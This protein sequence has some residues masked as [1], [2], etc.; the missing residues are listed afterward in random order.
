MNEYELIKNLFS[1]IPDLFKTDAS[2]VDIGKDKWGITCD[3]FSLEED[4]FTD[5]NPY[6]L[7]HNMAVATIS[8][9]IAT[10]CQ[11]TFY[12]HSLITSPKYDENWYEKLIQGIQEALKEYKMLL[13]GGDM[14]QSSKFAYTG[15]AIGKQIKDISRIFQNKKE[16]L[17]VSGPLGDFNASVLNKTP[18]PEIEIRTLPD[19]ISSC[20]DTSSGFMDAIWQLH[21][22][23]PNFKIDLHNVPRE[24]YA[25]LFGEAG[26]Y[27]YIFTSPEK[28]IKNA[29]CIGKVI[30]DSK[31]VF[32]DNH[33]ITKEPPHAR[34]YPDLKQYIEVIQRQLHEYFK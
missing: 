19:S 3:S 33:E 6:R 27:E 16:F 8:D 21:I 4:L 20:I 23:N 22:L 17:Y 30:P 26:E 29:I 9:L 14:G 12:Q 18:T 11:P 31:G 13:T 15:I 34:S 25:L 2:L 24:N 5:E 7:G 1:D 10:G 28:D 32:L